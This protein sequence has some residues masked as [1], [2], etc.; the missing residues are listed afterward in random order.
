MR[1]VRTV[2]AA[3]PAEAAAAA[4]GAWSRSLARVIGLRVPLDTERGYSVSVTVADPGIEPR[5]PVV[6]GDYGFGVTPMQDGVPLGGTVEFAGLEAPPDPSRHTL[7]MKYAKRLYPRLD[8]SRRTEWLGFRPSIPDSLPVIGASPR[9]T[10]AFLAF[11]HGHIGL[12]TAAATGR[13]IADLAAGR[14]AAFDLAPF[15]PD[16]F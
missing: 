11:G 10:N 2:T 7:L 5:L 13:A 3:Y 8:V 12:T 16:R 9:H 14:R 15:R 4:A 6:S 1:A